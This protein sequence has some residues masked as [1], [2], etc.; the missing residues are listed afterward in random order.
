MTPD[1]LIKLVT[2]NPQQIW[3]VLREAG[4]FHINGVC[5]ETFDRHSLALLT[6]HQDGADLKVA[7]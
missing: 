3:D 7:K 2:A 4:Y 6:W 1:G 5:S